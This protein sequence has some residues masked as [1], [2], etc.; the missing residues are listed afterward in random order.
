MFLI[1]ENVPSIDVSEGAIISDLLRC[2]F[3]SVGGNLLMCTFY[4]MFKISS[5]FYLFPILLKFCDLYKYGQLL[6]F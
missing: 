3:N 1:F 6:S 4:Y 2:H 5:E